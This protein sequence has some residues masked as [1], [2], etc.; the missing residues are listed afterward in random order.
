MSVG[1]NMKKR[2]KELGFNADYVAG[3][4]NVSRSTIF[5]YENGDIEKLPVDI[6][7][8]LAEILQTTPDKLMD[9]NAEEKQ[10]ADKNSKPFAIESLYQITDIDKEVLSIYHSLPD[11]GK[12]KWIRNGYDLQT[13]YH[14]KAKSSDRKSVIDLVNSLL[15]A[16]DLAV[17][18]LANSSKWLYDQTDKLNPRHTGLLEDALLLIDS[19]KTKT[20]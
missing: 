6:V 12:D 18:E 20:A 4:L 19:G 16:E 10:L 13:E 11:E 14:R 2:R 8:K 9:W 15:D 17:R 7:N 1:E 3:K 5:R